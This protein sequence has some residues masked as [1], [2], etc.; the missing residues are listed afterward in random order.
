MKRFFLLVF[1]L[2]VTLPCFA[3]NAPSLDKAISDSAVYL[4]GRLKSGSKVV[5]LNVNTSNAQ[6][7]DYIIDELS[8]YMVNGSKLIVVDRKNLEL[9]RQEMHFQMSGEVSDETAQEI[10]R[11]L[12]A[13]YIVSGSLTSL[14]STFRMRI[15]AISVETAQIAGM[16]NLNIPAGDRI[17]SALGS[18]AP[19]SGVSAGREAPVLPVFTD[20]GTK[21]EKKIPARK[22]N[23]EIIQGKQIPVPINI[24]RFYTA[25]KKGLA[26]LGYTTDNEGTGYIFF[27]VRGRD[28]WAQ[29]KLCYWEDEYWYEYVNS[30]NLGANPARNSIHRNY[31]DWIA[32]VER[33][34][35]ALYP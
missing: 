9:I 11:K 18:G 14:G 27:T 24:E 16:Q 30:N 4:E 7:S 20:T 12:G 19:A 8:A 33:Q 32:R 25:A 6:L 35:A 26:A 13:Q 34:L 31:D 23:F 28:W 15:Q 2:L 3:Q 21:P 17:I 5:V 10:G 1:P 29:I 22:G